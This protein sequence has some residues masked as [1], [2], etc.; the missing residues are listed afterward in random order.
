MDYSPG[1]QLRAHI[2]REVMG[3]VSQS[4][5]DTLLK[6]LTDPRTTY[7]TTSTGR[8][9]LYGPGHQHSTD[10]SSDSTVG[11]WAERLTLSLGNN[12]RGCGVEAHAC[13]FR[14]RWRRDHAGWGFVTASRSL[15]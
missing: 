13:V 5:F 2:D 9:L 8:T 4:A 12:L 3:K 7:S 10:A 6:E 15:R 1:A 14:S 11:Q